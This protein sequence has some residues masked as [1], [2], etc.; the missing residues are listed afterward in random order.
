MA[1]SP[2][3]MTSLGPVF[4][5]MARSSLAALALPRSGGLVAPKRRAL[6]EIGHVAQGHALLV[7][8]E[9]GD[10]AVEPRVHGPVRAVRGPGQEAA[11]DF[12]LALGARLEARHAVCEPPLHGQVVAELE[13]Q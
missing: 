9:L 7:A 3:S 1:L 8:H 12:V 13:V 11:L 5:L 10:G 2:F 6:G 4:L